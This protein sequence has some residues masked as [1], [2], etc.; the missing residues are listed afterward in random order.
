MAQPRCIHLTAEQA[1]ELQWV[2]DHHQKASSRRCANKARLCLLPWNR[3]CLDI[4]FHLL[5][6][7]CE[8][9]RYFN[10]WNFDYTDG[11][12]QPFYEI[13]NHISTLSQLSI[14]IMTVGL[15]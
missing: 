15:P 9:S 10:E 12:S 8:W 5:S 7:S 2:R 11:E 13:L 4:L 1:E 14:Y 6:S 3:P